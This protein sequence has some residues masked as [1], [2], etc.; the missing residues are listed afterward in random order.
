MSTGHQTPQAHTFVSWW[1]WTHCPAASAWNDVTRSCCYTLHSSAGLPHSPVPL[2]S[3][4][5]CE[6]E[7]M[8]VA[9]LRSHFR[10]EALC[11][12]RWRLKPEE[13]QWINNCSWQL[14]QFYTAETRQDGF[15]M[16][17]GVF[18]MMP[19]MHDSALLSISVCSANTDPLYF[20]WFEKKKEKGSFG[21]ILL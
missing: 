16:T 7:R 20:S 4:G 19:L 3:D 14:G 21:H 15:V 17:T 8:F 1:L 5:E 10:A 9:F 6:K 11:T 2:P 12:W 13:E 18:D